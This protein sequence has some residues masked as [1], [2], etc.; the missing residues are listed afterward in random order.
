ML[1]ANTSRPVL[2]RIV[3]RKVIDEDLDRHNCTSPS[4]G[5]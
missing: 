2:C 3:D 4:A 5:I 1:D